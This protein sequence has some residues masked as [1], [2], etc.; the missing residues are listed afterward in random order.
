MLEP[1]LAAYAV[2]ARWLNDNQGV[3]GLGIFLVTLLLGWISGIFSALRHKPKLSISCIEGP[4]FCCTFPVG[5]EHNG[6]EVHR[7]GLALYLHVVNV[8][9]AATSLEGI[10]V[11]YHWHLRPFSRLWLKYVIGWHWLHNQMIIGTDF[12]VRI[13]DNIKFYPFLVQRSA[14]FGD[15]SPTYLESGRSTNGVVYFEQEDSW[16][17]C[18]PSAKQGR[19]LV[20]VAIRD[21][22]G[23]SHTVKLKIPSVTMEQARKFN[24]SFGQTFADLRNEK[25]PHDRSN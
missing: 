20:Q 2:S 1:L 14:V 4:T 13:G 5:A 18:F 17:G 3:A 19:V 10:S 24:P 11:G 25:L 6:Y 8:G 9:T 23:R 7:T 12:Q 22:Y 16:G 21:V 15:S